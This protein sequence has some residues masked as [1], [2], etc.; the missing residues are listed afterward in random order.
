MISNFRDEWVTPATP[1]A[2]A[3][4]SYDTKIL[5]NKIPENSVFGMGV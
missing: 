5:R 3:T 4:I 2:T 1:Y